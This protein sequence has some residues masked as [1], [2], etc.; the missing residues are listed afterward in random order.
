VFGSE[1]LTKTNL[2]KRWKGYI[3]SVWNSG[4]NCTWARNPISGLLEAELNVYQNQYGQRYNM[5]DSVQPMKTD[6]NNE[7]EE[8]EMGRVRN[9]AAEVS[10]ELALPQNGERKDVSF[11]SGNS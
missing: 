11:V 1:L 8:G 7:L 10:K 4:R 2:S 9:D 5:V 6:S 3:D